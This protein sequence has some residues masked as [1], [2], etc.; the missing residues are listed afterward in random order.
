[1]AGP[2]H[3]ISSFLPPSLG[4]KGTNIITP[5]FLPVCIAWRRAPPRPAPPCPSPQLLV[6]PLQP[7]INPCLTSS[8][9]HKQYLQPLLRNTYH[10]PICLCWFYYTLPLHMVNGPVVDPQQLCVPSPALPSPGRKEGSP[11][12]LSLYR[13]G[14][15]PSFVPPRHPLLHLYRLGLPSF[16]RTA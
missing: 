9:N 2:G 7:P 14:S 6:P 11:P 5:S 15:P 1:V 10:F 8:Y 13:L 3:S 4:R 12:L 16:L